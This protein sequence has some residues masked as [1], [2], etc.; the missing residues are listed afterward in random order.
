MISATSHVAVIENPVNRS[1][2]TNGHAD[3]SNQEDM[4]NQILLAA[5]PLLLHPSPAPERVAIIGWGSGVTA[6]TALRFPIGAL[7][8]VEL[9]PKVLRASEWF[10]DVNHDAAR[11]PRVKIVADDGRNY[12]LATP[13]RF[14]VIISEPSNAWQ[15]GVC[16]LFT[17]E[18]FARTRARL[19]DNG[20]FTLWIGYGGIPAA[21]VRGVLAA[22]RAVFSHILLFRSSSYDLVAVASPAPVRI[23]VEEAAR[24]MQWPSVRADLE[25][26]HT[27]TIPQLLAV[28][29]AGEHEI[30]E[31]CG[32]ERPNT[33]DNARL[34]YAVARVYEQGA[35]GKEMTAALNRIDRRGLS[36]YLA[37][38]AH[39]R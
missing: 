36:R 10:R 30:A 33:D 6:G 5:L 15:A 8:A 31:L 38:S 4:P 19:K 23:A 9:E 7:T 34:E 12:L 37:E 21:E 24:R 28:L 32:A 11:D 3:A 27:A 17:Q 29:Q 16:N 22:L 25:R 2:L 18:Y 39:L 35:Q 1:L 13:D 20:L 26:A 14:D